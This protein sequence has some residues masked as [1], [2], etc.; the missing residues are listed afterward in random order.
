MKT[1]IVLLLILTFCQVTNGLADL[2]YNPFSFALS[3]DKD[4]YYEGEKITFMLTIKNTDKEKA[5]P[6][7]LPRTQ[8]SGIKIY[9]LASL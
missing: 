2:H 8:N 5:Y 3:A 1:R 9:Y 7:L 4:S 6:I